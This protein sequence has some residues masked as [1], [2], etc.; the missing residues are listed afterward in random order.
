MKGIRSA[1]TFLCLSAATVLCFTAKVSANYGEPFNYYVPAPSKLLENVEKYHLNQGIDKVK[2]GKYEYAW[3]E[4]AFIL[5]YFPNH[6]KA[7]ELVGDLSIQMEGTE[8]AERYF[9][10][11]LRLFP[12]ES[13]T[14][15]LHGVFL[16]KL[17]KFEE[18]VNAYQKAI[19]LND[20]VIDY[21][22]NLG[23]SYFALKDYNKANTQAS[24]AY[25]K[26]YPLPGLQNKLEAVNAWSKPSKKS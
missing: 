4:F 6:P 20:K 14:H 24:I 18:A 5:H 9:E 2:Q 12:N 7:L 16:H 15:A 23:L 3:S 13:E 21:H 17:E 25:G 10:T 11:A 26:G 8:R 1:L 22:Y 19:A